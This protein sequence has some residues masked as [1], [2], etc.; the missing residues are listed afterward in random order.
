M[1][2]ME[3]SQQDLSFKG[4]WTSINELN[5]SKRKEI[6]LH[7]LNDLNS[8]DRAIISLFYFENLTVKE[9]SK[10]M[11]LST[12]KIQETLSI[13]GFSIKELIQKTENK[14]SSILH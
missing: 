13:L 14:V 8:L 6:V 12:G 9:I 3:H 11:E 5:A 2:K 1:Q 4:F 7:L 10:V